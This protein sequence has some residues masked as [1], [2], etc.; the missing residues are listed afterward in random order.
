ME[1][2]A[3]FDQQ[4]D[5]LFKIG[6]MF[7]ARKNRKLDMRT[8]AAEQTGFTYAQLHRIVFV[9]KQIPP[10]RRELRLSFGHHLEVVPLPSGKRRAMLTRALSERWTVYELRRRV[11]MALS[12]YHDHRL[13]PDGVRIFN[14]VRWVNMGLRFFHGK[15]PVESWPVERRRLVARDLAPL[16]EIYAKLQGCI[17]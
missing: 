4:N 11:R 10:A 16:M 3:L 1:I 17:S 6:D 7:L 9:C 2:T 15:V 5:A 12:D 8:Y 14:V 13:A